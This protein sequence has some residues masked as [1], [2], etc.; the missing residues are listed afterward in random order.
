[1]VTTSGKF[2]TVSNAI[3]DTI[4]GGASNDHTVK[5]V[6]TYLDPAGSPYSGQI[7]VTSNDTANATVLVPVT[8]SVVTGVGDSPGMPLQFQL[9][10][11]YPNPFNP[12]TSLRFDLPTAGHVK[13]VVFD[14]LGR[15]V[16]TLL[17]EMVPAGSHDMTFNASGLS[18][19]VYF[20]RLQAGDFVETKT[21]LLLK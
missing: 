13:L 4:G 14:V 17:N 11:N 20:Y 18:S 16:A 8:V 12:A 3:G 9:H 15:E 10:Q 1:V 2:L 6:T 21:L 19:G 5:I 7:V